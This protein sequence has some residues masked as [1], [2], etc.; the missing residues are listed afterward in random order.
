MIFYPRKQYHACSV[1]IDWHIPCHSQHTLSAAHWYELSRGQ[2]DCACSETPFRMCH[3]RTP[4]AENIDIMIYIYIFPK[5]IIE[6]RV[7][8][9]K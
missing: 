5:E 9:V 4:V 3:K 8:F 6:I 1:G 7:L 2:Q